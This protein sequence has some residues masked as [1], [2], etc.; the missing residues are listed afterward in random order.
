MNIPQA[1]ESVRSDEPTTPAEWAERE[2]QLG[3]LLVRSHVYETMTGYYRFVLTHPASERHTTGDAD[4]PTDAYDRMAVIL[5]Q[6]F[7]DSDGA[8]SHV[9]DI[10][11]HIGEDT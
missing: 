3:H 1:I 10:I 11:I 4:S 7:P 5:G 6:W 9:T 8:Q 2:Q